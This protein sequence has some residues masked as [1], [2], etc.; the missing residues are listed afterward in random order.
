MKRAT[1]LSKEHQSKEIKFSA[2]K[3]L[4]KRLKS[5]VLVVYAW[6]EKGKCQLPAISKA[7]TT[8]TSLLLDGDEFQGKEGQLQT[9]YISGETEK[10]LLIVGLGDKKKITHDLIR[11]LYAKVGQNLQEL[12]VKS[13]SCMVPVNLGIPHDESAEA[14]VF[15]LLLSNYQFNLH[16][17]VS[18]KDKPVSIEKIQ[19]IGTDKKGLELVEKAKKICKAVSLSK[20]LINTNADLM[21][22][23]D[24]VKV[25]NEI[26]KEFPTVKATIFDKK[27]IE[28]E[29]M[30]LVLAVNRGSVE[31]DP[32]FIILEYKGAPN[33]KNHTALI[34][35]GITFDTG[36]LNL[37]P[38]GY[39]ETMKADMGGASIVL[40]TVYA[41]AL[42][43]LKINVTAIVP[44]TENA[45]ASDSFKPGD[46]YKS[47][48]GK[49]V[50]IGNTDAEGR[51]V[52][53]DALAWTEKNLKPT[54]MI[55]VA[56]LTGAVA[57]AL[58]SSCAGL[59]TPD[60]DLKEGLLDASSK[61][62]EQLWQLPLVEDY[63]D[64][65]K[66]HVADTSNIGNREGGAITAALFLQQ[67]VEKTPWAHID[68]AGVA[69]TKFPRGVFPKH[70]T[71]YG[72]R[73]LVKYLQ[74]CG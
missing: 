19:L 32:A 54:K 21:R 35:K 28:K 48:S 64:D 45:I 17:S 24:L 9:L 51:L 38:T 25:A 61:T 39:M 58:G 72:V 22:P 20:D 27:R 63:K 50:E 12:K 2:E 42:L 66:S 5:D 62:G 69:F 40:S 73:L 74:D 7:W 56:T 44:A 49:T 52:L 29:K 36:G 14:L 71:G 59:L 31:T 70:A 18:K 68:V 60:Q 30:G 23:S 11:R 8:Q 1:Y 13:L 37:K 43:K 46:V 4:S 3:R 34:G 33:G 26:A 16:K 53:A 55:D 47:Y 65:L 67:F 41:A 57:V 15:G 10:R 6:Q